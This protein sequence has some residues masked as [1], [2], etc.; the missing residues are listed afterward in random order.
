M[1]DHAPAGR[2]GRLAGSGLTQPFIGLLRLKKKAPAENGGEG[3][4]RGTRASLFA[5]RGFSNGSLS[6]TPI[7]L[8]DDELAV[9]MS[10]ARPLP[11]ACRDHFLQ[12]VASA[13][14]GYDE[15][16]PG[17][18]HRVIAQVQ[19]EFFDPPDLSRGN[20]ASK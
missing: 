2:A 10:A 19:R 17:I 8:N 14:Q 15:I 6:V 16:G 12:E 11:V 1:A 20:D 18:V 5:A 7:K 13:L 9:V 4:K 3:P